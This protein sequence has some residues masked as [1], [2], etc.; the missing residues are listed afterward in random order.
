MCNGIVVV[1]HFLE[2]FYPY[3]LPHCFKGEG[4]AVRVKVGYKI[5]LALGLSE[6]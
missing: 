1:S 3:P 2:S 6:H 5:E 4:V